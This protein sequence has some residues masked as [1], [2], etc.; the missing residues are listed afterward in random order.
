M[1]TGLSG[2]HS[3]T[4]RQHL[5]TTSGAFSIPSSHRIQIS[6]DRFA[7]FFGFSFSL[8]RYPSIY[9]RYFLRSFPRILLLTLRR[10]ISSDFWEVPWNAV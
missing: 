7:G 2:K 6:L 8:C 4:D 3:F 10:T 5:C 9:R 1:W